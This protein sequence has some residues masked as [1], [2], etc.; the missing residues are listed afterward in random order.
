M[1]YHS[2]LIHPS[3]TETWHSTSLLLT[4]L[5]LD[6]GTSQFKQLFGQTAPSTSPFISVGS[7]QKIDTLYYIILKILK[8]VA[9]GL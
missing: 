9:I 2:K 6:R 1:D 3:F 8:N 5:L 7:T 4:I